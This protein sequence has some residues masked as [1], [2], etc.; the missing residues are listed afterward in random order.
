M[1][2]VYIHIPFC[3]SICSYCD[4]CKMFYHTG[5]VNK[6]LKVLRTEMKDQYLGE[7]ISSIYIGGGTPSCL[8]EEEIIYLLD[9]IQIFHK[10]KDCEITFECNV[11]DITKE[12]LAILKSYGINRLSIGVESFQEKKL[13]LMGRNHTFL[14]V[15]EKMKMIRGMGF[16]NINIDLI[17]GFYNETKQDI[18][19]DLKKVLKLKP[20]HI[21]T[22]SLILS[23]HTLLHVNKIPCISDDLDA[24]FYWYICGK[25]KH[26]NY[27]HYEVSNFAKKGYESKHNLS[28]WNNLEYYGFGLSASGYLEGVRYMNTFNL[29]KY[30]N[31]QNDGKK[32]LLTQNDIMDN[33]IM[34]GLRKLTGI[35]R[36][37]FEKKFGKKIEEAYPIHP[38]IKT[39]DLIEK[40]GYIFINP[41]K[42]YVMNE[43]LMKLI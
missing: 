9:S 25:L 29:T 43:I 35:N 21:S 27:N 13:I 19:D 26:R 23:E 37:D 33:E 12:K 42:I 40:D 2:A 6:Y 30:L 17:Y 34:L 14:E 11:N 41:D 5:W 38:L 8:S 4:F 16:R 18:K 39:K 31:H 1:R 7:K 15:Q 32:E 24:E 20:E 28:Y 3:K 36:N 10:A 22:Y